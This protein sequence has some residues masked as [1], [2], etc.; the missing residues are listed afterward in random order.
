MEK[1]RKESK[2]ME[3]PSWLVDPK[4]TMQAMWEKTAA[5]TKATETSHVAVVIE[6]LRPCSVLPQSI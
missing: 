6:T 4:K 1:T 2:K 5:P 3:A